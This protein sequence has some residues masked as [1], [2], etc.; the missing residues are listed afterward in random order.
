[1]GISLINW[2]SGLAFIIFGVLIIV[3]RWVTIQGTGLE[4]H[5]GWGLAGGAG[6]GGA[7]KAA[8]P[9]YLMIATQRIDLNAIDD[10]WLYVYCGSL[11]GTFLGVAILVRS[12]RT[13]SE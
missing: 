12:F 7:V 10:L 13:E 3:K 6:A 2:L 9:L 4:S 5:L 11:A 1:M 8:Y